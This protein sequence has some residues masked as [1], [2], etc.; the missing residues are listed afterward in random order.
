MAGFDLMSNLWTKRWT[1]TLG[2]L[3]YHDLMLDTSIGW[4][5]AGK[6]SINIGAR[7]PLFSRAV[8]A[9]L[10]TP[11]I[12]LLTVSRPFDLFNRRSRPGPSF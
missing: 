10:N 3:V 11:A 9:Q 12:G 7:V 5:F 2:A 1:F 8:G 6:W 4:N